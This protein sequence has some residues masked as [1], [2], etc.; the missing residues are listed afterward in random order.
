M[1]LIPIIAAASSTLFTSMNAYCLRRQSNKLKL[2]KERHQFSIDETK[3][4]IREKDDMITYIYTLYDEANTLI[5]LFNTH[6]HY[7]NIPTHTSTLC[8]YKIYSYNE[9][10]RIQ[11]DEESNDE[12]NQLTYTPQYTNHYTMC[13]STNETVYE[14]L[15]SLS[16][17]L[18]C[19][20][21]IKNNKQSLHTL[22]TSHLYP[23]IEKIKFHLH[24]ST[25]SFIPIP[26]SLQS[27]ITRDIRNIMQMKDTSFQDFLQQWIS[28]LD[29]NHVQS[30]TKTLPIKNNHDYLIEWLPKHTQNNLL[31]NAL[32]SDCIGEDN[33]ENTN[34]SDDDELNDTQN[35][36]SNNSLLN[37]HDT[38]KQSFYITERQTSIHF[39]ERYS[40]I[41]TFFQPIQHI[42]SF[43]HQIDI[44]QKEYDTKN[45]T[46]HAM[47]IHRLYYSIKKHKTIFIKFKKPLQKLKLKYKYD[48]KQK[49]ELYHIFKI[50]TR[51]TKKYYTKC[52]TLLK[53]KEKNPI[54]FINVYK[55]VLFS[56]LIELYHPAFHHFTLCL[57][58]LIQ[59]TNSL[60]QKD[61]S[62]RNAIIDCE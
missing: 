22:Y 9:F 12:S 2:M 13:Y 25:H 18:L 61:I 48:I 42:H 11:K 28:W 33:G 23:H 51:S 26:L 59:E 41:C 20:H 45:E 49:K 52:L 17:L 1:D 37:K 6:I 44:L 53:Q 40:S 55:P 24:A 3:K 27:K 46:Y 32:L 58:E 4:C 30:N 8:Y 31:H 54:T 16:K 39:H 43:F 62:F 36:S 21:C 5:S 35:S 34:E 56:C 19:F 7:H 47:I 38:T 29:S 10:E 57:K 15:Y 14:I 50:K 60:I